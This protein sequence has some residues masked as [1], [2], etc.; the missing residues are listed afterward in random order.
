L[1]S[2]EVNPSLVSNETSQAYSGDGSVLL[3]NGAVTISNSAN[4]HWGFKNEGKKGSITLEKKEKKVEDK[5]DKK[6]KLL[7][8][9]GEG[10]LLTPKKQDNQT[11]GQFLALKKLNLQI[12]KGEFVCIIGDVGS[13]KSSLL[14]AL[15]GDLLYVSPELF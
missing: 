5:D 7:D 11:L 4:F 14:S 6:L 8:P 13:G 12:R 15:I 1:L 2:D 3:E 10:D 9:D